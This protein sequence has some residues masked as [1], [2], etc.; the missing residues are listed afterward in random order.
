M[1]ILRKGEVTM[2]ITLEKIELVKDRTGASYKAAKE[3]L[4]QCDG[5]V[6]EAIIYIEEAEMEAAANAKTKSAGTDS[7]TIID[8]LKELVRKGNITKIQFKRDGDV[9]LNVP[10]AAGAVSTII[11]P[12]PTVVAMVAALA[13]KCDIQIVKVDGEI[14]DF[15]DLSGGRINEFRDKAEDLVKEAGE[16]AG[17]IFDEAKN[18]AGDIFD[19]AKVKAGDAFEDAKIKAGDAFENAK[20]TAQEKAQEFKERRAQANE[21]GPFNFD[22]EGK[23]EFSGTDCGSCGFDCE[24]QEDADIKGETDKVEE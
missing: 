2:E 12:I 18:K 14:I 13:A 11:F 23:C 24:F 21:E 3:A 7:A 4:E 10:V 16:K 17:D 9:I 6:V 20:F 8:R 5:N 19:D 22:A 1:T 15:N